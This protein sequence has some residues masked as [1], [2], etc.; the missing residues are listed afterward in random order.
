[1]HARRKDSVGVLGPVYLTSYKGLAFTAKSRDPIPLP[2][3]AEVV[4]AEKIWIPG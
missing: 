2:S 1:V 3:G 4:E